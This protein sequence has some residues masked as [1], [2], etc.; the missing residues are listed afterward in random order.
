MLE[1]SEEIRAMSF[2]ELNQ[3]AANLCLFWR[4]DVQFLS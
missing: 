3:Q 2:M 1:G 4:V